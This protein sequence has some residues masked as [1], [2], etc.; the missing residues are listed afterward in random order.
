MVT[1]DSHIAGFGDKVIN[2]LDGRI[3]DITINSNAK[4]NFETN[5]GKTEVQEHA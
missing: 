3:T 2:L 4:L 1:H 5:H